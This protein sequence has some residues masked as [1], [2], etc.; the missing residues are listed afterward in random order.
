MN[1]FCKKLLEFADYCGKINHFDA[2]EKHFAMVDG[3]LRDGTYK[4][5]IHVSFDEIKKE[6]TENGN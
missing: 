2:Y 5:S 4:F 1:I 3:E 6:D